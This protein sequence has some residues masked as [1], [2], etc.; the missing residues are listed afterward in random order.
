MADLM[1]T[2][3]LGNVGDS[4]SNLWFVPGSDQG[5]K[6]KNSF[7]AFNFLSFPLISH[8]KMVLPPDY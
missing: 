3:L 8:V 2:T 1:A 4:D 5:L 7:W 6:K